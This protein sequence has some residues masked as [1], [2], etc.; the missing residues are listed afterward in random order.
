[1]GVLLGGWLALWFIWQLIE[2]AIRFIYYLTH[3]KQI[4]KEKVLAKKEKELY[5]WQ[6]EQTIKEMEE[7]RK[8]LEEQDKQ[9]EEELFG[10]NMSSSNKQY[11]NGGSKRIQAIWEKRQ[12]ELAKKKPRQ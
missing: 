7:R 9:I 2:M 3:R 6:R 12:K 10:E 5:E 11:N 1:M 4:K 8:A